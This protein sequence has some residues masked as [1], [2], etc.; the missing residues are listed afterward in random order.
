M[1]QG[2]PGGLGGRGNG[3]FDLLK[4]ITVPAVIGVILGGIAG[5]YFGMKEGIREGFEVGLI[6]PWGTVAQGHSTG[7][8]N[9][10]EED[11]ETYGR[12]SQEGGS[13]G[14]VTP[15]DDIGNSGSKEDLAKKRNGQAYCLKV[16]SNRATV[17][18]QFHIQ[19]RCDLPESGNVDANFLLFENNDP[20]TSSQ[21]TIQKGSSTVNGSSIQ[22]LPTDY[23]PAASDNSRC[24]VNFTVKATF[25][26]PDDYDDQVY[27]MVFELADGH[28][29]TNLITGLTAV[30]CSGIDSTRLQFYECIKAGNTHR[31]DHITIEALSLC[32]PVSNGIER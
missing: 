1:A 25:D 23:Q 12:Q 20:I 31:R 32:P 28:P 9:E 16:Q 5:Y 3:I 8:G 4:R 2:I 27:S 11:V 10:D 19:K 29:G 7:S 24:V 22:V 18:Y 30:D 26:V 14:A 13:G 6:P 17:V 21:F 15:S